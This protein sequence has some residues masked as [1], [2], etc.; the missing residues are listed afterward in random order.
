[1]VT[2]ISARHPRWDLTGPETGILGYMH[3][4]ITTW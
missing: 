4:L 3:A 2:A 1:M